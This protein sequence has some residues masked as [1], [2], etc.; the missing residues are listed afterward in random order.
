[1]GKEIA[2]ADSR[3]IQGNG[4]SFSITIP[5]KGARKIGIDPEDLEDHDAFVVLY[6]DG[7]LEASL[8]DS[9]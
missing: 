8:P 2:H 4:D 5:K 6:K 3:S 7:T 9:L 1:M